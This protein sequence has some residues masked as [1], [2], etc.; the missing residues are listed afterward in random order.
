V[1]AG[2]ALD[3]TVSVSAGAGSPVGQVSL[4]DAGT[5]LGTLTLGPNATATFHVTL[6]P[7]PGAHV[8]AALFLGSS[9][10]AASSSA[11]LPITVT[12]SAFT[13][14]S[15]ASGMAALTPGSLA[16]AFGAGLSTATAQATLPLG[17]ALGGVTIT[18]TDAAGI[19]LAAL[20]VFVSP[21][22]VNFLMPAGAALGPAQLKLV[23][24]TGTFLSSVV[25]TAQAP[26]L[27]S[28]DSSGSGVAAAFLILVH[29]DR[30]QDVIPVFQCSASACKLVPLNL[31][32][33]S[34]VAVLSFYGSGFDMGAKVEVQ[35]GTTQLT[36]DY[37]G[38]QGQY[39]GLDQVNVRLPGSLAGSGVQQLSMVAGSVSN[40]LTVEFQ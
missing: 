9:G 31:G 23:S 10:F 8:L 28:A 33:S 2:T 37:A 20:L 22:Q 16:S 38:P 25:L 36:P 13:T 21:S 34:D 5:A 19:N 3:V 32:A 39:P 4:T 35:I 26:A 18:V 11:V 29:S 6:A 24:A 7:G 40:D 15:S 30:R 12:Q 1:Q 14:V 27:F 17:T